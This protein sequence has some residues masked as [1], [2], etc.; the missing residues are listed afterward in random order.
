MRQIFDAL[1]RNNA[2]AGG[3]YIEHQREQLLIRGE[4]LATQVSDLARIV[5]A[6]GSGGVAV[7]IA[8][9]AEVKEGSGLR[10]GAA[11]AMGEG[12]TVIG[13]V[14]MLAGE[15]AQQVV[16][17]VKARV[18]EIQATLPSGVTI[19]PYYDR[20]I[21]V[22]KVMT[23][24]RNNLLEGG[25]LVVAV[26]FLF[27][28]DLRAG[29]IVASAI[30]LAMLIAFTGMMQAGLSGNLMSLGAIDFGLLVD[31]SVVMIDNIL[32]RLADKPVRNRDERL[33]TVLAAGREV[34]RP[35]TL[36]VSI[37][38][39]VYVPILA[40]TGIEGKMFRP[41]AFTVIMALAGSLLLAVTVTPLLSACLA[42]LDCDHPVHHQPG[43]RNQARH[44]VCAQAGRRRPR[45]A[46]VA[47]AQHLADRIGG[48]CTRDRAGAPP[49]SRG[50]SGG[51]AHGQPRSGNRCDG[52]RT[53]RCLHHPQ[54]ATGMGD[55][56]DSQRPDRSHETTHRGTGPRC[57]PRIH[58]TDRNAFQ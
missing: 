35:M 31:G 41:M 13:M 24:V 43:D 55:S 39:L 54:A 22:S 15:N 40:L 11:T 9:V 20:T 45:A 18:Q 7:Y 16:T 25:L 3:G 23:T 42:G 4:A 32:R 12:E 17:R 47:V 26:L 19:E 29:L 57:R 38:I 27:L 36:A 52:R 58:P 44:R 50:H 6:H 37:I 51:H 34:L 2:I 21:F 33:A 56:R 1:Q 14:Q 10:I 48:H 53:F 5:V 30:P 8:D 46:S 28:G 49:F